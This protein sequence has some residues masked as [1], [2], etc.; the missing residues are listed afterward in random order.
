MVD[1]SAIEWGTEPPRPRRNER[2]GGL[3][4]SQIAVVAQMRAGEWG[5]ITLDSDTGYPAVFAHN[6]GKLGC[7]T[8]SRGR[9][10]YFRYVGEVGA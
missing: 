8:A 5:R 4:P 2:T 3:T 1:V 9:D 10:V 7:E 6:L